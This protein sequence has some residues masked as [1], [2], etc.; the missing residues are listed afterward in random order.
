MRIEIE[1]EP[2]KV[3]RLYTEHQLDPEHRPEVLL[4]GEGVYRYHHAHLDG[5]RDAGTARDRVYVYRRVVAV[6]LPTT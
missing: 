5:T 2:H 1:D 3:A 6:R 4:V